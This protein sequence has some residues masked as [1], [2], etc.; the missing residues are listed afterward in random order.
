[1]EKALRNPGCR[2]NV[3]K[4][5]SAQWRGAVFVWGNGVDPV[6][7]WNEQAAVPHGT[8]RKRDISLYPVPCGRLF[9]GNEASGVSGSAFAGRGG[10]IAALPGH[11]CESPQ[12]MRALA[13]PVTEGLPEPVSPVRRTMLFGFRRR[14]RLCRKGFRA[15][16]RLPGAE[17]VKDGGERLV[18]LG[19]EPFSSRMMATG[20]GTATQCR[21]PM[22]RFWR[23]F[24]GES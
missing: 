6:W 15:V 21:G 14:R 23:T 20:W 17:C 4:G 19:A 9:S 1:M 16:R 2:C 22:R 18:D 5:R 11:L 7:G 3:E 13:G 24:V 10:G 8:G 12:S